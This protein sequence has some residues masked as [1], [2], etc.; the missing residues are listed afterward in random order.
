MAKNNNSRK[1]RFLSSRSTCGLDTSDINKR[2]LFNFS[3]FS[4]SFGGE[5][6]SDWA[7]Q[8]NGSATLNNLFEKLVNFTKEPLT[9][10]EN[11]RAGAGG[12]KVLTYYPSFPQKS[13]FQIPPSVPHDVRWGRFRLGNKVR[14]AGFSVPNTLASQLDKDGNCFNPNIFYVVFLDKNHSFWP[15]ETN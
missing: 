1:D 6:L 14:V 9:Y 3:Y 5:P 8:P 12:L 7:K 10:W 13:P 4:P 11:E 15:V 2:C